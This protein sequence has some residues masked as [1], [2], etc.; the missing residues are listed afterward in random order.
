[1][2]ALVNRSREV[3]RA[4]V[5]AAV[6][7]RA[8]ATSSGGVGRGAASSLSA[9]SWSS[10]MP[11]HTAWRLSAISSTSARRLVRSLSGGPTFGGGLKGFGKRTIS[12]IGLLPVLRRGTSGLLFYRPRTPSRRSPS[13]C[14][15]RRFLFATHSNRHT[16]RTLE[17]MV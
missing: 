8:H 6:R 3:E 10:M 4:I 16:A 17:L 12:A 9:K 2:V 15:E 14:R 1:A 5:V 11:T 13:D 7:P